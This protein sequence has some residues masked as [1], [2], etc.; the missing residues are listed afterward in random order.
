MLFPKVLVLR[1]YRLRIIGMVLE[2]TILVPFK[3]PYQ[4]LGQF[5][6]NL[7]EIQLIP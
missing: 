7:V 6:G 4:S 3:K 1:K 5:I 2:L